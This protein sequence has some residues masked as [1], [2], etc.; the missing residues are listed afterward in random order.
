MT[1]PKLQ[2]LFELAADKPFPT[3]LDS[4]HPNE[5]ERFAEL[6]VN[7]CVE[8]AQNRLGSV[9]A[10]SSLEAT[11]MATCIIEDIRKRFGVAQ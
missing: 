1:S 2:E 8:A 11:R 3:T 6:I 4:L 10:E 5:L 7:E 9:W